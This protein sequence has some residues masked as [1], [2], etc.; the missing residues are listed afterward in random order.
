M[1]KKPTK[2]RNSKS[3][4]SRDEFEKALAEI[5]RR[6]EQLEGHAFITHLGPQEVTVGFQRV[7]PAPAKKQ[8]GRK[9]LL[10][11]AVVLE[12]R[13]QLAYWIEQDW[14]QLSQELR[15]AKNADNALAAINGTK[16]RFPRLFM[17]PFHN[18]T[19]EFAE[20]LWE[21]LKSPYYRGNPRNLAGAMAGLPELSWKRSLD[22]CTK[23]PKTNPLQPQ[24]WR[25]HL[26]RKFPLRWKEL[27]NVKTPQELKTVFLRTQTKDPTYVYLK[28]HHEEAF[29]W[30]CT[31]LPSVPT[32]K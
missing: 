12:R 24:A 13:G 2:A 31:D 18:N 8:R 30:L 15:R 16:R 3:A 27:R 28:E 10:E 29:K 11:S 20:Q 14:P 5:N 4:I 23:H 1:R 22:I 32:D 17:P 9:P 19:E 7:E 21:F 26:R 25:D 6:L